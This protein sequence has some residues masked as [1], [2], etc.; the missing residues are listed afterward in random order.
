MWAANTNTNSRTK[1]VT[2]PRII[3]LSERFTVRVNCLH[4][5]EIHELD[6][7]N[8]FGELDELNELD[9]LDELDEP[10][11]MLAG[12]LSGQTGWNCE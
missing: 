2:T 3:L 10:N 9:E 7:L 12:V 4:E 5:R 1:W 6:E 8:E 11:M